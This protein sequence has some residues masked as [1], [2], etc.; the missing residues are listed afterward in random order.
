MYSIDY[1]GFNTPLTLICLKFSHWKREEERL[2]LP[3][4]PYKIIIIC[5]LY[6]DQMAMVNFYPY[7]TK[8]LAAYLAENR[9]KYKEHFI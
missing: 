1:V 9:D 8:D 7:L 6:N 4:C 5:L 3:Q 2:I